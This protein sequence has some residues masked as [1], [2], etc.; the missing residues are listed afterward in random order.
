MF[1]Y[2][3]QNPSNFHA[4]D[5]KYG[6]LIIWPHTYYPYLALTDRPPVTVKLTETETETGSAQANKTHI[7]P[8]NLLYIIM[9]KINKIKSDSISV[10]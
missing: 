7:R 3:Q 1:A 4:F 10:W 9:F 8:V 2:V 6:I 5:D